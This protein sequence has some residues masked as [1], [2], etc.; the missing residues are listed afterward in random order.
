MADRRAQRAEKTRESML[1]AGLA[2]L[3]DEPTDRLFERLQAQAICARAGVTTGSFY[4]HF[5][6]QDGF[7][8]ALLEYTLAKDQNPPFAE[9]VRAFE[10]QLTAGA[11]FLSAL[12][13]SCT[14]LMEWQETNPTFALQLV[15][16]AKSHRDTALAKRL[17]RMYR[18]VE[19]EMATYFDAILTLLGREMRPPF[20]ITDLTGTIMAV[21]EGLSLRRTVSSSA[22]PPG[23]LATVV[24]PTIL[25]MTRVV[26]E[27]EPA[28]EW[29]K[30]NAPR[31][32]EGPTPVT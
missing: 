15:V 19:E 4:H 28:S 5:D 1:E 32:V 24:I 17:D 29:L 9:A 31:W 22:M 11:S 20:G 21:F 6:G 7:V 23:R 12:T 3:H 30:Q 13:A 26:G 2:I 18:L 10:E 8:T 14:H 25:V 16:T 27:A